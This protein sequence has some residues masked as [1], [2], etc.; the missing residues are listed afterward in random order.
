VTRV[1]LAATLVAL[2][3]AASPSRLTVV[4]REGLVHGFLVLERLDGTVVANGDL[5]Q[6]SRG[7]VV[8]SRLVF[9]FTDGSLHDDTAE[10]SQGTEFRLRRDHLIQ[11]GPSFPRTIDQVVDVRTGRA[12]V[13]YSD[14][15]GAEKSDTADIS[16]LKDPLG[17]GLLLVVLKNIRAGAVPPKMSLVVATPTLRVVTLDITGSGRSAFTTGTER[18]EAN[19][20]TVKMD[21]G[22]LTGLVAPLVGKQP[23]DSR[24]WILSGSAPAFVQSEQPLYAGGPVWRIALSAP[25]FESP[26]VERP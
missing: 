8:T 5:L 15:H 13:R 1:V 19:E 16:H 25:R 3:G 20:Y 12:T 14:E 10:F 22:G 11:K 2:A 6:T 7:D 26:K 21:L 4:Q 18:R 9:H 17:N 24:V 23:P